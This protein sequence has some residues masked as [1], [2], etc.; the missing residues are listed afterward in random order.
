MIGVEVFSNIM[1]WKHQAC[2]YSMNM[3][4]SVQRLCPLV[5]KHDTTMCEEPSPAI[6]T[7][8]QVVLYSSTSSAA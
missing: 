6:S 5:Y 2:F 8:L 7:C 3:V 4:C 1:V